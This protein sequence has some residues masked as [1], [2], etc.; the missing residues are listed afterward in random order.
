MHLSEVYFILFLNTVDSWFDIALGPS[1][2][3]WSGTLSEKSENHCYMSL[4][5][6]VNA[7]DN[8]TAVFPNHGQADNWDCTSTNKESWKTVFQDK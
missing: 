5:S 1:N 6:K 4:H 3:S 2:S 8:S 7:T